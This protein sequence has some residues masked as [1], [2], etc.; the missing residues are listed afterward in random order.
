MKEYVLQYNSKFGNQQ[1][2]IK[3]LTDPRVSKV[4][5]ETSQEYTENTKEP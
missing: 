1:Y 4:Y 3:K 5:C 2:S